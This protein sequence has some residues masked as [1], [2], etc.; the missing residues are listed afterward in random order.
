MSESGAVKR[1]DSDG[2]EPIP[3]EA[4]SEISREVEPV[5]APSRL[6]LVASFLT[7]FAV[8][9]CAFILIGHYGFDV[10]RSLSVF[11][12]ET[13][14]AS[15]ELIAS[16]LVISASGIFEKVAADPAL[17]PSKGTEFVFFIW[18][19][20]RKIPAAGEYLGL[21]GKFDATIRSRPGYAV[22]LEGAPDGVRPRVYWNSDSENGKWYSFSTSHLR[23]K[24]WYLLAISFSKDAFLSAH[25]ASA[26]G[27]EAVT[28]LGAHRIEP[29]TIPISNADIS[30]G[31]FGTS[32]F[33]G[34]IGPFGVLTGPKL[35]KDLQEYL[36]AM[37]LKPGSIPEE[38]PRN[39]VQLWAS[40]LRDLGPRALA[41]TPGS[42]PSKEVRPA[43]AKK[44]T[45]AADKSKTTKKKGRHVGKKK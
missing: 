1:P 45:V 5:G 24:Q 14:D 22:T 12:S 35:S 26:E 6:A 15:S 8:A 18:F 20:L 30:V 19:K 21:A 32:R 4:T 43:V 3:F 41:I 16:P 13:E 28:L 36:M 7:A 27:A 11:D 9:A 39:V 44:P 17:N 33:R 34:Q 31:A 10:P 29:E 25:I 37:K 2:T 38:V 23:R 42:G 40:P